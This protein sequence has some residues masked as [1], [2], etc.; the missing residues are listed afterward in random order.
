MNFHSHWKN[1]ADLAGRTRKSGGKWAFR[2]SSLV[3]RNLSAD[4]FQVN[5]GLFG[6][7]FKHL[8]E[9]WNSILYSFFAIAP[10]CDSKTRTILICKHS[11]LLISRNS[12]TQYNCMQNKRQVILNGKNHI[13]L[14]FFIWSPLVNKT[15]TEPNF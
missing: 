13:S 6:F 4:L 3:A 7:M 8:N 1:W 15:S 11:D 5:T 2:G 10:L 9:V 14:D 12:Q